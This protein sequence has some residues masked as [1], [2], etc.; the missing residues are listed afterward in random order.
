MTCVKRMYV[1]KRELLI[2]I[3]LE[4]ITKNL[5]FIKNFID[6]FTVYIY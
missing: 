1:L 3:E 5:H 4:I 2:D 6:T